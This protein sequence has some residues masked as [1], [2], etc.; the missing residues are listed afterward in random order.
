M[1]LPKVNFP[2][3]TDISMM[4]SNICWVCVYVF[5]LW[6]CFP[7]S[8]VYELQYCGVKKDMK[9]WNDMMDECAANVN[10]LNWIL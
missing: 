8:W 3:A 4:H 10:L 1:E 7:N 6:K 2:L 9:T 5:V